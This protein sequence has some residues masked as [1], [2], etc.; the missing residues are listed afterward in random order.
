[1]YSL[2]GKVV[3]RYGFRYAKR[4]YGRHAGIV[5]GVLIAAAGAAAYLLTREVPE[6]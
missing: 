1:M 5:L 6:G 2:I 3:V 4:R